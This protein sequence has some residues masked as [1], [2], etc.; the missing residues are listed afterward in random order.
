MVPSLLLF[1]PV[2]LLLQNVRQVFC[3][4]GVP[5]RLQT[6]MGGIGLNDTGDFSVRTFI[7]RLTSIEVAF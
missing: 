3:A 1:V 4:S 6:V 7:I 2:I 5:F